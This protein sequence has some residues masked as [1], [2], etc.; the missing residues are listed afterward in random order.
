MNYNSVLS[1]AGGTL[2]TAD[3]KSKPLVTWGMVACRFWLKAPLTD[4]PVGVIKVQG[5]DDPEVERDIARGLA[6][7]ANELAIWVPM[8][9][10][11]NCVHGL[12]S[13]Q[14]FTGP[15][16]DIAWDGTAAL[17]IAINLRDPMA[18]MRIFWDYTSGGGADS[19]MTI[20]GATRPF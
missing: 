14:T 19:L 8:T 9:L 20:R 17:S 15:A 2:L 6:G 3:A 16:T 18:F 7:T 12:G 1:A 13:G 5:S 4:T 11:A 10:H